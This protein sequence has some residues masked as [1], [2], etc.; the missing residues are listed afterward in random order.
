MLFRKVSGLWKVICLFSLESFIYWFVSLQ[1]GIHFQQIMYGWSSTV[2]SKQ[3][4]GNTVSVSGCY[5]VELWKMEGNFPNGNW[6][7]DKKADAD[8]FHLQNN[9]TFIPPPL[10]LHK[11]KFAI[12]KV[13][14]ENNK[15]SDFLFIFLSSSLE[16]G[17]YFW[18]S[19]SL[20]FSEKRRCSKSTL[21]K[22]GVLWHVRLF[23]RPRIQST[24]KHAHRNFYTKR[25]NSCVNTQ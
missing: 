2:S 5:F 10:C 6:S 12:D 23:I 22:K 19:V 7:A 21:F 1:T 11:K 17:H 15:F 13:C 18:W 8:V 14:N 9:S 4:G 16:F 20:N 3:V 25:K 24:R